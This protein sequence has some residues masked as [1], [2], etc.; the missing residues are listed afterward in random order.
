MPSNDATIET[1]P[2]TCVD[3]N[4]MCDE[5]ATSGVVNANARAFVHGDA[6]MA[7][8]NSKMPLDIQ[9]PPLVLRRKCVILDLNGLLLKRYRITY[10]R[11]M[12]R[13]WVRSDIN[14]LY[15]IFTP[16]RFKGKPHFQY[17]VR[18]NTLHFI[19]G[20]DHNFKVVFWSSCTH[21]NLNETINACWLALNQGFFLDVIGQV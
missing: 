5:D 2:D 19:Q 21:E 17:V 15:N 3:I 16:S 7:D 14:K 20:C 12:G 13:G 6:T 4:A 9:V 10:N 8:K 18:P 11:E 1:C